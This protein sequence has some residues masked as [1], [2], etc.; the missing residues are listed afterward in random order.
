[1]T[2]G[3]AIGKDPHSM[4]HACD[5]PGQWGSSGLL[6]IPCWREAICNDNRKGCNL[7]TATVHDIQGL[8]LR[9]PGATG[10]HQY[11]SALSSIDR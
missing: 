4:E 2:V 10:G 9:L 11:D 1:M 3:H 8:L 6:G 5:S 7:T